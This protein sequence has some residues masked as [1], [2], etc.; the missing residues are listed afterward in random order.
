MSDQSVDAEEVRHVA[1]L[2]RV[3]LDEAEVEAFSEQFGEILDAFETLDEVPEIE[4]EDDLENV[5]RVDEVRESLG[6][7]EALRNAP[8]TEDGYFKGPSV[9]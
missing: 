8:E 1:A 9:S 5:M 6:Q 2:A 7:E 3:D 4:R